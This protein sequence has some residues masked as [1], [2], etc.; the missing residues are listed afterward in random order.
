MMVKVSKKICM[1]L[2]ALFAATSLISSVPIQAA[3][4][5]V[6]KP[7]LQIIVNP[8]PE[9]K[10]GERVSLVVQCPNYSEAVEYR[11]ILWDGNKK[12]QRE[13]WP[14]MPGYYY[15]KWRPTGTYK[16][17]IGWPIMEPGIYSLTVLV[18]RAGSKASYE[19]FVKT[20]S[21][22]VRP[23]ER[24]L[25]KIGEVF[26][27]QDANA[28]LNINEDLGVYAANVT[29]NN[30]NVNGTVS[31]DVGE[32]NVVFLNN[33]SAKAI[34]VLSGGVKVLN[35]AT[36]DKL[37]IAPEVK[38]T[39]IE[40]D[41][42]FNMVEILKPTAMEVREDST[43][44]NIKANFD[45]YIYLNDRAVIEKLDKNG[46]HVFIDGTGTVNNIVG[47]A[48]QLPQNAVMT[49]TTAAD[50]SFDTED[51][52]GEQMPVLSIKLKKAD[53]T[54]LTTTSGKAYL[55]VGTEVL[56]IYNYPEG[57]VFTIPV[58]Q[59][60]GTLAFPAGNYEVYLPENGN[61]Y[62]LKFTLKEAFEESS[63]LTS[64]NDQPYDYVRWT[65]K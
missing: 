12:Q 10:V 61:Y 45:S 44:T 20:K 49:G 35:N 17:T 37:Q 51:V 52:N 9:Y 65:I 54:P 19:S 46:K 27:S 4:K 63:E 33:V 3:R 8:K 1:M 64:V 42:K 15:T 43:I 59:D 34:K 28:P 25:R 32:G 22:V 36:L 39:L 7:K 56:P 5:P 53:G 2:A 11:V 16:F 55:V 41:G 31:I 13:L 60:D 47:S 14:K 30:I 58:N 26:G 62:I 38:E 57:D 40:L 48:T 50:V 21:F 23:K 24:A 29:L 18:R 6:A